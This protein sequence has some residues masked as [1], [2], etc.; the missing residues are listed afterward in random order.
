MMKMN[1]RR[2]EG[3]RRINVG[4]NWSNEARQKGYGGGGG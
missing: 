3:G 4:D 2:W 1:S